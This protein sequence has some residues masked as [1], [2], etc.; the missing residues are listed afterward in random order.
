MRTILI[1]AT[2]ILATVPSSAKKPEVQTDPNRIICRSSELIGSRLQ[3]KKTCLSAM[4]WKQMELDQRQ[5]VERIQSFK[6]AQGQ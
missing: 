4:R 5:T 1:I 2:F 3:T 6:P